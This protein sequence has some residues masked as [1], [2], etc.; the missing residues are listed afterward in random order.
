LTQTPP[1]LVIR[2]IEPKDLPGLLELYHHLNP[3]DELA[4]DATVR[5]VW[6]Q[7]LVDPRVLV[8]VGELED[9]LVTTCT[10]VVVPNLMR[11]GRP[12]ALVENV[13]T[14]RS[15]R[16]QGYGGTILRHAL[17]LAWEMGCYKVMLLTGSSREETLRFYEGAGFQLGL[18]TGLVA[19]PAVTGD[20]P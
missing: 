12:Y 11:Q 14:A 8:F 2:R 16:R 5:I 19:Y 9:V 13:V 10:L 6:P 17:A 15:Y 18:K 7:L 3:T 4:D 20:W 1:S